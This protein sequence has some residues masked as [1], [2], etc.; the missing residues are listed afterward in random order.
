[1]SVRHTPLFVIWK[2]KN[3]F[4]IQNDGMLPCTLTNGFW[5]IYWM[6]TKLI[7]MLCKHSQRLKTL[8]KWLSKQS[9]AAG[10]IAT[11]SLSATKY[12][13]KWL[14]SSLSISQN[15]VTDN[16]GSTCHMS[17]FFVT[18][19]CGKKFNVVRFV[20][21]RNSLIATKLSIKGS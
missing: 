10:N 13:W 11:E 3:V 17:Q 6:L 5:I 12:W 2:K 8:R 16:W 20:F 19:F 7:D 21:L 15:Q 18:I 1:M 14:H 9:W 4:D